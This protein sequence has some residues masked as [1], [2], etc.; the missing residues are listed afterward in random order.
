[1]SESGVLS[2]KY[3]EIPEDYCLSK[4]TIFQLLMPIHV[5]LKYCLFLTTSLSLKYVLLCNFL[6]Y[7]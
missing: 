7:I 1:M 5:F 4:Y 3:V 2:V 6:T